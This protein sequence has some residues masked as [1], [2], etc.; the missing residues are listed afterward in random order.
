M[1]C[2][3]PY[4]QKEILFCNRQRTYDWHKKGE[5]GSLGWICTQLCSKQI[6]NKDLLYITWNSAQCC[7]AAWMGGEFGKNEYMYICMASSLH[8]SSETITILLISY[9]L[10]KSQKKKKRRGGQADVCFSFVSK[11]FVFLYQ[12]I[13]LLHLPCDNN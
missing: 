2:D 9:T 8:C 3:I 7:M 11:L 13:L 10:I 5:L 12:T 4:M 1:S 6:T